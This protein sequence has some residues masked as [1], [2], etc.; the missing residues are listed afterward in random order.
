M[1]NNNVCVAVLL[2]HICSQ[3]CFSAYLLAVVSVNDSEELSSPGSD[4]EDE[5]D[6]D[7][8]EEGEEEEEDS[9]S[10]VEIIEEVQGNGRLQPLQPSS[11]FVPQEHS[12]FLPTLLEQETAEFKVFNSK[13]IEYKHLV[14]SLVQCTTHLSC[15]CYLC[16]RG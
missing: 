1:H 7:D 15:D 6:Q 11:V 8:C 5:S 13:R 9:G 16:G 4:E 2:L 12:D 10:E 14:F 3:T